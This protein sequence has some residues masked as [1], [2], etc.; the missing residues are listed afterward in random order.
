[1]SGL[2]S[3]VHGVNQTLQIRKSR[4][5]QYV[6]VLGSASGVCK[7]SGFTAATCRELPLTLEVPSDEQDFYHLLQVFPLTF[8]SLLLQGD[9]VDCDSMKVQA[10]AQGSSLSQCCI[11]RVKTNAASCS[12]HGGKI[13]FRLKRTLS[14]LNSPRVY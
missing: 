11:M 4:K 13:G 6:C 12:K 10:V 1:M 8:L 9:W 5:A 3:P 14:R 7:G 2:F